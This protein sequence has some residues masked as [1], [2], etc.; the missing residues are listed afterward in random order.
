[1]LFADLDPHVRKLMLDE[2]AR[3]IRQVRLFR[4]PRLTDKGWRDYPAL[5][6][7]AVQ[8]KD[9]AWL[10]AELQR[11]GRL[12]LLET[13]RLAGGPMLACVPHTAAATLA[14]GEFNRFYIR[15]LCLAALERGESAVEICRTKPVAKARPRSQAKIG[16]LLDAQALLDDLRTNN[17]VDPALGVPAGPNSGL[18]VKRLRSA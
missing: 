4:S 9:V 3:D 7:Q 15:A 10:T 18:S 8:A 11:A 1:M 13:R 6:R 14:E 12:K 5:L 17:A 16:A 2:V